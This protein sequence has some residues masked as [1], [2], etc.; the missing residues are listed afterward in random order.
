MWSAQNPKLHRLRHYI[1]HFFR[2]KR[3]GHGVHSPFVYR[4]CE[5]VFYNS[6]SF[7]KEAELDHIRQTLGRDQRIL[8]S[9]DLGAGST[10]FRTNARTVADI[11][12]HGISKP[13][14]SRILFHLIRH[15]NCRLII[16]L[17]TSLGLNT[18]Y[19]AAANPSGKVY[20]LEGSPALVNFA[21]N[22][23]QDANL[24]N[25]EFRE[26]HFDLT[27]PELLK[28]LNRVDLVYVDG[29]HS[30]EATLRYFYAILEKVQDDSV[31]VFD[32][33]YWSAG[34]TEAWHAIQKEPAVRLS[35]DTYYMGLVFFR[36][37]ILTKQQF[38]LF[39]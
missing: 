13:K 1:A 29:N 25:I 35:I 37:D 15:L 3:R 38:S 31:L 12:R 39:I 21:S 18:L 32:D 28:T 23:A 11:V 10:H 4:L 19:L 6:A 9:P 5:E 7:Y 22:L 27:L 8:E 20:S 33:I 26:G 36:K 24:T 16:E 34:M 14:Q 2:S 17:G 30:K